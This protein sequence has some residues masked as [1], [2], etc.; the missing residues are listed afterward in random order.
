MTATIEEV[1]M[2][3]FCI[4]DMMAGKTITQ[5]NNSIPGL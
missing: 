2:D 3:L 1:I 4:T 5:D